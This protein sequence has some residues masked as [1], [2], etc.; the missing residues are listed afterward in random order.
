VSARV[1]TARA[2]AVPYVTSRLLVIGSLALSRHVF[3]TLHLRR[4]VQLRAGLL[5]WD[6]A[7]YRDIA[8]GGY[9]AV[10]KTGLR[11]FPLV[12]LL[13]RAVAWLPGID[14]GLGLLIVANLSALLAGV[15]LY[16]LAWWERHDADLCRRA[17]W[18]AYL[19]PPAFVFVM[20]YAE[21]T[22]MV[23]GAVVLFA[24]RTRRWWIAAA[25]GFLAG[26][27]RPVGVLVAIPTLVEALRDRRRLG[28]SELV[29]RVVAVL[30]PIAGTASYLLWARSRT[31][32][33]F[34]PLRVQ[35]EASRRGGWVDPIRGVGHAVHEAFAG[36]H[37]SAGIHAITAAIL[38]L[39]L[40]VL[41][42]RWPSSYTAYAGAT[43]LLALSSRNLDS[44]ERYSLSTIPF[45]L[46]AADIV[47]T[48]ARERVVLVVLGA[49]L[50]AASILAFTGVMVP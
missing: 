5:G 32:D 36:D 42:R 22:L 16:R 10:D 44:I 26:I 9:D 46:A 28:T 21:A 43:L 7:W 13:A 14:A 24:A 45:V 30:A 34:Y 15:V 41:A 31:G 47:G 20:G 8:R 18:I 3:T 50:V 4:P 29:A 35:E 37:V 12:P 23:F 49:G 39:L 40:V 33:F 48:E 27:T 1:A 38:V 2:V 25:A 11:F 19:A 6:A 17:L